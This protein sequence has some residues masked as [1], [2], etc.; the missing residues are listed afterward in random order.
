MTKTEI[1]KQ[2]QLKKISRSIYGFWTSMGDSVEFKILPDGPYT[3]IKI[4]RINDVKGLDRIALLCG[5]SCPTRRKDWKSFDLV[6]RL[7]KMSPYTFKSGFVHFPHSSRQNI[8]EITVTDATTLRLD[9]Y[10]FHQI[11]GLKLP[12]PSGSITLHK[13]LR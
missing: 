12:S 13:T 4:I 7:M 3:R 11:N 6:T 10:F 1:A 8:A 9:F 2:V 5:L